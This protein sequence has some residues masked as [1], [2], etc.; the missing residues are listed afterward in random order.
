MSMIIKS[1]IILIAIFVFTISS[2]VLPDIKKTPGDVVPGIMLNWVCN[3]YI[4]MPSLSSKDI[5]TVFISYGISINDKNYKLDQLVPIELGG[6]NN[7]KNLWPQTIV[8]FNR[9]N[10]IEADLFR[11]ACNGLI[12]LK[13]AQSILMKDWK[14]WNID[15]LK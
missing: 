11:C 5:K 7:I 3:H 6:S 13:E 12:S 14:S 4:D 10:R 15:S 9:K 2:G 1:F 8:N